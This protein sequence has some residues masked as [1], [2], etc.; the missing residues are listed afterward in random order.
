MN[1]WGNPGARAPQVKLQ[2]MPGKY[3]G[4]MDASRQILRNHGPKGFFKGLAAPLVTVA[5]VNAVIFA[6]RG[7]ME[8]LLAHV[9]GG[10]PPPT[11]SVPSTLRARV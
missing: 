5:A 1:L 4:P 6:A 7:R 8:K 10:F 11:D 2:S 3:T 9:D